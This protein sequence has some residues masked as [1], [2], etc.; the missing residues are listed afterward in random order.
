VDGQVSFL[1]LAFVEGD[2]PPT[3]PTVVSGHVHGGSLVAYEA[4]KRCRAP[5]TEHRTVAI[6]EDRSQPTSA[7]LKV[8]PTDRV[9]ASMDPVQPPRFDSPLYCAALEA[10]GNEIPAAHDPML[11]LGQ[12]CQRPL[13]HA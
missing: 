6:G 3:G 11:S 8:R 10:D 1:S 13:P 9:H 4:P 5:M 12:R 2:A 7:T